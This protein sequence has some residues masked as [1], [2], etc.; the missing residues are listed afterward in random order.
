M[1]KALGWATSQN[2]SGGDQANW[3]STTTTQSKCEDVADYVKHKQ[4]SPHTT[5]N[6]HT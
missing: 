5:L 3:K 4:V 6:P 2:A 1:A